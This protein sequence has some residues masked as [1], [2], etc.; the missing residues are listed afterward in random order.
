MGEYDNTLDDIKET[1]GIVSDYFKLIPH[2]TVLH[3][4]ADF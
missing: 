3:E 1:M 4:W 2:E